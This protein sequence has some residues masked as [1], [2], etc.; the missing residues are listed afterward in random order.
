MSAERVV[1]EIVSEFFLNTCQLRTTTVHAVRAA[2]YCSHVGNIRPPDD[3]ETSYIPLITGSVAEFY[4]E[5][6]LPHIGDIDLMYHGNSQLAIPQGHPPPSQLSAEF[7]NYVK[8]FEIID[9]PYPGYVFLALRYLLTECSEDGKYEAIEYDRQPCAKNDIIPIYSYKGV[10]AGERHGPARCTKVPGLHDQVDFVPCLRCLQWPTQASDWPTR[11]RNYSWP[12]A[13]TL[14]H[15]FRNGCDVVAV[16]HRSARQGKWM[17]KHQ[18]RLSFSRAEI[19]LINSWMHEQQIVYH[20]LRYFIKTERL[21]DCADSSGAGTLS[22]YHIKTLMLW[23]C[24]LKPV[25]WWTGDLNLV[26]LCVEMLRTLSIWLVDARCPHYFVNDSNLADELFNSK[27]VGTKLMSVCESGMSKWFVNHYI[28]ECSELCLKYGA[29]LSNNIGTSTSLQNAV[30]EVVL[31]RLRSVAL[32]RTTTAAAFYVAEYGVPLTVSSWSLTAQSC[33]CCM[34]EYA[35]IDPSLAVYFTATAF[36][37][38]A[39]RITRNSF[40][41]ELID[42][43]A[44]LLGQHI[45]SR[46]HSNQRNSVLSL[47]KAAKL[48]SVIANETFNSTNTVIAI[49]LIKAYLYRALKCK[50]SDSD[51]IYCLANVYLA[52][53]YYTTGQYQT[54]IDHCTLVTRSQDH[55]ECRSR[56]VQGETLPKFDRTIDNVLG[57]TVFYQYIQSSALKKQHTQYDRGFTTELFAHYLSLRLAC[58]STTSDETLT[59]TAERYMRDISNRQQ[60]LITDALLFMHFNHLSEQ[61]LRSLKSAALCECQQPSKYTTEPNT[62]DLVELLRK[63]AVEHLTTY[64]QLMARDFGSE[65]TLVT[66]DYEALYAYKRGD[67]QRCL[68]L[69]TQNVHTLMHAEL[70]HESRIPTY[71]EFVHLM[72]DDIVSLTALTL[73]VNPECRKPE[74]IAGTFEDKRYYVCVSQ[75][76]LSLYLMTQCRLKL[77]NAVTSRAQTLDY[78]EVVQRRRPRGWTLEQLTLRL[79]RRKTLS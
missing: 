34:T 19:V 42:V 23:A 61:K 68:Q 41:D 2:L 13:A 39:H 20:M 50:D 9:S 75:L 44:T 5:P 38:V 8:V 33:V 40:S 7:H 25:S 56:V 43:L 10:P 36:L 53:L 59:Q 73:L 14:D 31:W 78:I 22:N 77:H 69:S 72:D 11:H 63:S 15:V 30:A 3:A 58:L 32:G 62:R 16:A 71:P 49:E 67:Y 64:R 52:V 55:S 60:L 46:R 35:K 37:H 57:L 79:I 24:E 1:S 18:W 45:G 27:K 51:S 17:G 70:R 54:A 66:T 4:I 29:R 48:M 28:T 21:T 47:G 76:T 12:D 6:M 26:R 65:A 74:F